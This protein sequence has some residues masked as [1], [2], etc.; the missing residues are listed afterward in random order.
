M[1]CIRS[2]CYK[3]MPFQF[4]NLFLLSNIFNKL[5]ILIF[6]AYA[7]NYTAPKENLLKTQLVYISSRLLNLLLTEWRLKSPL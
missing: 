7:E 5:K 2:L 4:L 6:R 1:S 3:I